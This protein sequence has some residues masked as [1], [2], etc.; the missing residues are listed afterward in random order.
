VVNGIQQEFSN[1]TRTHIIHWNFLAGRY[2]F[3]ML[4]GFFLSERLIN[5][6]LWI[7]F[8]SILSLLI[9][10]FGSVLLRTIAT[11][12]TLLKKITEIEKKPKTLGRCLQQQLVTELKTRSSLQLCSPTRLTRIR[13][14]SAASLHT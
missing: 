11:Y 3:F 4:G 9:V 10:I 1:S 2:V 12:A 14:F 5:K 7:S 13:S 6:L 8:F